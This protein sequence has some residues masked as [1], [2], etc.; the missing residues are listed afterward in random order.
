LGRLRLLSHYTSFERVN[1]ATG[2]VKEPTLKGAASALGRATT[3]ARPATASNMIAA[4]TQSGLP[5]CARLTPINEAEAKTAQSIIEDEWRRTVAPHLQD[6]LVRVM[7]FDAAYSGKHM[8]RA[9]HR[10]GFV[11]NC[12]PVSHA[13]RKRSELNA[14]RRTKPS[15][16]S[17]STRA[18]TSTATT[19]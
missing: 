6:D 7:A 18:G 4:V 13:V 12:H 1:R 14:K 11:P 8:R 9:V 3:G 2:E 17:A 10:A 16:K 19:N 15:S 5:L